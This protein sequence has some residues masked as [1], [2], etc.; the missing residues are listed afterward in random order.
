MAR[1][2]APALPIRW[3]GGEGQP[4]APAEVP[5]ER[6]AGE[7]VLVAGGDDQVWPSVDFARAV[8]RRRASHGLGT[9]VVTH[10]DAGH[11]T[12]LPGEPRV[13]AG[14]VMARGGTPGADAELGERAWPAMATVLRLPAA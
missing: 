6:I 10:P 2:G 3:F 11:R 4:S 5:L 7:V 1:H 9:E 12:V 14:M 13:T 8:A